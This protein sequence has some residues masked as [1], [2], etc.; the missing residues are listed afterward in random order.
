VSTRNR[1]LQ[2]PRSCCLRSGVVCAALVVSLWRGPLPWIHTH[3]AASRHSEDEVSFAR[4]LR[5]FHPHEAAHEGWHVH[6]SYPWDVFDPPCHRPDPAS[7]KPAWV[8]EM[9]FVVSHAAG[10]TDADSQVNPDPLPLQLLEQ[11]PAGSPHFDA[12]CVAG[13]HFMQTYSPSVPLRALICVA[14]C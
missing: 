12:T 2:H 10:V 9:P 4:H 6:F 13:L 7:P 11:G 1:Q 8:Y 3:E 14:Q 5:Q